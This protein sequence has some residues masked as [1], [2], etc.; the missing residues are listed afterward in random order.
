MSAME[1]LNLLAPGGAQGPDIFPPLLA[2]VCYLSCSCPCVPSLSVSLLLHNATPGCFGSASVSLP[3]RLPSKGNNTV[4][5][6]FFPQ[7]MSNPVPSLPSHLPSFLPRFLL[8]PSPSFLAYWV[9]S[10]HL[11]H[12]RVCH[13]L[14]PSDAV[15]SSEALGLEDVKLLL[16]F[17][18]HLP[19]FTAVEKH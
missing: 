7:D 5:V 14:L 2:V 17:L 8:L 13:M 1:K 12:F 18:C 11:Q 15:D 6:H 10:C 9:C 3:L 4:V 19:R 16:L